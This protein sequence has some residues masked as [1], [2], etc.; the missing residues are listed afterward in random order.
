MFNL[1]FDD[2]L[3]DGDEYVLSVSCQEAR[4]TEKFPEQVFLY[5][6]SLR[7]LSSAYYNYRVT[8]NLQQETKGDPFAQPVQVFNNIQN[9]YGIF[10]AFSQ[11]H[12][13]VRVR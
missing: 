5:K 12:R 3:F 9:G 8:Y 1:L 6:M 7:S 4:P 2:R 11:S 10:A 13:Q